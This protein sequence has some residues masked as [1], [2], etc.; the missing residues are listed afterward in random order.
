MS[1]C[2]ALNYVTPTERIF[3]KSDARVLFENLLKIVFVR[4][5]VP[6][7]AKISPCIFRTQM[8]AIVFMTTC[9]MPH[10]QSYINPLHHLRL[11]FLKYFN[12]ILP[13]TSV[14]SKLPFS[15]RHS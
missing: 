2:S 15:L 8:C 3:I 10:I 1:V 6:Q 11:Y 12:I 13:A 7:V 5:L 9:Y 4:L 14:S